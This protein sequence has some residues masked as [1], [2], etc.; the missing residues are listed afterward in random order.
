MIRKFDVFNP[1]DV[2]RSLYLSTKSTWNDVSFLTIVVERQPS[3]LSEQSQNESD[4]NAESQNIDSDAAA[5]L[6]ELSTR[7][8][9]VEILLDSAMHCNLK[10]MSANSRATVTS[11]TVPGP[12]TAAASPHYVLPTS[13]SK[14]MTTAVKASVGKRA[15]AVA[16]LPHPSPVRK[17]VH[18]TVKSTH[19]SKNRPLVQNAIPKAIPPQN[20]LKRPLAIIN[21]IRSP[22]GAP[23]PKQ[24]ILQGGASGGS[25]YVW[26]TPAPY[27]ANFDETIESVVAGLDDPNDFTIEPPSTQT[28]LDTTVCTTTMDFNDFVQP[29]PTGSLMSSVKKKKKKKKHP[30]L[31]EQL[32]V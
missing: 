22:P 21:N 6:V 5:K 3:T 19:A 28:A 25:E 1:V 8:E 27:L 23:P 7:L 11:Q 2:V 16:V 4:K 29:L 17:I 30:Y 9:K 20:S 26:R 24:P 32:A 31:Q 10:P 13:T 14:V 18:Q 15:Q 12:V